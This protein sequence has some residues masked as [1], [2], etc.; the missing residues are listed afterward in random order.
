VKNKP[1]NGNFQKKN[2]KKVYSITPGWVFSVEV[3][4]RR[5]PSQLTSTQVLKMSFFGVPSRKF[6]KKRSVL[7]G[8]SLGVE[9][10]AVYT[11]LKLHPVP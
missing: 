10:C 3:G 9:A 4:C 2:G 6:S 11:Y 5:I 8:H 1:K 7:I